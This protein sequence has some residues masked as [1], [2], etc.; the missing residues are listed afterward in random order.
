MGKVKTELFVTEKPCF[1]DLAAMSERLSM[2][3]RML[4]AL[5][6]END[7]FQRASDLYSQIEELYQNAREILL[8]QSLD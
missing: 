4:S 6:D 1:D 8:R 7:T 2:A 3:R 5:A